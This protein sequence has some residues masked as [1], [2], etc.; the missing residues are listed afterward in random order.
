MADEDDVLILYHKDH[1]KNIVGTLNKRMTGRPRQ[2]TPTQEDYQLVY[3]EVFCGT[4]LKEVAPQLGV[5]LSQLRD[6]RL[7]NDPQLCMQNGVNVLDLIICTAI[8]HR[9]KPI[10]RK[11]YA[12][13]MDDNSRDQMAAMKYVLAD[14]DDEG[15]ATQVMINVGTNHVGL[16][17]DDQAKLIEIAKRRD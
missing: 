9:N 16:T 2:W 10:R 3:D 6:A 1:D 11:L 8:A 17:R 5:T 12:K 13:A 7:S 15:M 14:E 4:P